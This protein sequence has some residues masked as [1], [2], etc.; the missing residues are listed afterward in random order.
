MGDLA[1]YKAKLRQI[2]WLRTLVFIWFRGGLSMLIWVSPLMILVFR[3]SPQESQGSAEV[4]GLVGLTL[5]FVVVG[6][7]LA[8]FLGIGNQVDAAATR[9]YRR[10]MAFLGQF[11]I[12]FTWPVILMAFAF[13]GI[14]LVGGFL[15]R[16][17]CVLLVCVGDP[18]LILAR[19]LLPGAL[20]FDVRPVLFQR[21]VLVWSRSEADTTWQFV[22]LADWW[23]GD[24]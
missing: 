17:F 14:L 10:A 16:I 6:P 13:W 12:L 2:D 24:G 4:A 15:F 7:P 3:S 1:A 20:P 19:R 21:Y 11:F 5:F 9:L 22:R 23:R 8:L 18:L